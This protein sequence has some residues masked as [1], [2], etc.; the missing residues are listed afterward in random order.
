MEN[1]PIYIL[2]F[3]TGFLIFCFFNK[4]KV[5]ESMSDKSSTDTYEQHAEQQQMNVERAE[6]EKSKE[7]KTI[8]AMKSQSEY[9]IGS[10]LLPTTHKFAVGGGGG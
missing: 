1:K 10:L 9:T 8:K 2:L 6:R 7:D 3:L 4:S 5:T